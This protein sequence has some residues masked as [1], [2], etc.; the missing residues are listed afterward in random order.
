[1]NHYHYPRTYRVAW[2]EEDTP[3]DRSVWYLGCGRASHSDSKC[4][5]NF[6]LSSKRNRRPS[7][8]RFISSAIC[9]CS[10]KKLNNHFRVS[11]KVHERIVYPEAETAQ[12]WSLCRHLTCLRREKERKVVSSRNCLSSLLQRRW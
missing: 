6:S 9:I 5:P 10:G 8:R 1:M 2:H 7:Y 11:P 3:E 4:C 12:K